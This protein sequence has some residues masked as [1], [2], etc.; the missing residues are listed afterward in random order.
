MVCTMAFDTVWKEIV[1]RPLTISGLG[2]QMMKVGFMKFWTIYPL[3]TCL[4]QIVRQTIPF[5]TSKDAKQYDTQIKPT[6]QIIILINKKLRHSGAK[7]NYSSWSFLKS[8]DSTTTSFFASIFISPP[9][10]FLL[11]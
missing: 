11:N 7:L 10:A 4:A 9:K 1:F 6:R 5:S 2:N 3:E 8:P